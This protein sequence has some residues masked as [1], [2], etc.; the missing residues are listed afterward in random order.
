MKKFLLV[1]LV[2]GLLLTGALGFD[3]ASEG[4]LPAPAAAA[5]P[6]PT[7]AE[8]PEPVKTIDYDALYAA[9]QPDELVL[10]VGDKDVSW[11]D[12][13]YY[14]SRQ[15]Q[16]V[17]SYFAMYGMSTDWEYP[18]DEDGQSLQD[19]TLESANETA[20]S[21]CALESFAEQLG[22]ELSEDDRATIEA[23]AQEDYD[24]AC[25]EGA[26]REDFEEYLKTLNLPASLYD[27]MNELSLLYQQG[28]VKLYGELGDQISD[29]ETLAYL[30]ANGY[31]SANHILFKTIDTATRE[32]LDEETVAAKKAQAEA[33]A[34]ELQAIED[35]DALLERFAALKEELD[36]DSGKLLHP[37]GYVFLPGEMVSEF[38]NTAKSQ[39]LYQVSDPVES[40]YGYHV[41]LTLP[42]DPDAVI[43]LSGSG[44][45]V[46][47][48]SAAANEAYAAA[49]D[50]FTLAQEISYAEGFEPP[51]LADYVG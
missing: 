18:I 3:F 28:F 14:L 43:K 51:V 45:Q 13:F 49:L 27:R 47:A 48:R 10:K 42:L 37:N 8:T 26:T 29:E 7:P 36:E 21:L 38:E 17:E 20:R 6:Q 1:L 22:V 34:A 40:V 46:S 15:S 44:T 25:G 16:S 4:G 24:A 50:E 39:E 32:S 41:I 5:T 31:M 2:L 12:Y 35:R 33:T 11:A 23:K 19:F 9:H 30:E